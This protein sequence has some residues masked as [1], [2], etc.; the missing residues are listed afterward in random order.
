MSKKFAFSQTKN[1]LTFIVPITFFNLLIVSKSNSYHRI[2][3]VFT[4]TCEIK[5]YFCV[6]WTQYSQQNISIS[7]CVLK[8]IFRIKQWLSSR[9]KRRKSLRFTQ[10]VLNRSTPFGIFN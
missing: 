7:I 1:C 10:F 2:N 8:C 9:V 5:Q 4:V 3:Y 6:I